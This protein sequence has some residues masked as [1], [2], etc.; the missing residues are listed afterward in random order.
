ML[1][2]VLRFLEGFVS[3]AGQAPIPPLIKPPDASYRIYTTE[4]D[5]TI[6]GAEFGR[7]S[8]GG[9]ASPAIV[10]NPYLASVAK[11][12][13]D[14][15]SRLSSRLT[16]SLTLE[17]R[18][19]TVVAFLF[20]H[21]GSLRGA[22][23]LLLA[24][25]A[26]AL[27]DA[28]TDAGIATEILGFTTVR[29][30]G[31][32]SREKWLRDGRPERPGRLNDL[33]HIVHLDGSN[34]PRPGPHKFRAMRFESLFKE[35]I[36]GEALDWA[37]SRMRSNSRT[38]KIIIAVSDGAPVDDATIA[39]NW[40]TILSEHLIE[41]S[42]RIASLPDITLGGIG[43]GY[44]I[45]RFYMHSAAIKRIEALADVAPNFVERLIMGAVPPA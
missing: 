45:E 30:K 7:L 8:N 17:Q 13:R 28:L 31:G 20:D 14:N 9:I 40:S 21:S 37:C 5:E 1:R 24:E 18:A 11:T 39:C 36:D 23:G 19:N 34:G 3:W 6:D 43:I 2:S 27:A 32:K 44:G 12:L 38:R 16:L 29:W 15:C 4:F 22:A 25:L 10:I 26:E 33:L 35:N 42:A 41:V